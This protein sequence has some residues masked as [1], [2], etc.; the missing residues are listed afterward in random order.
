LWCPATPINAT[1]PT[2]VADPTLKPQV[3]QGPRVQARD[4][5]TAQLSDFNYN[6]CENKYEE[7]RKFL[8]LP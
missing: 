5:Y 8:G 2:N 7:H 6:L 1:G 3:P 4:S